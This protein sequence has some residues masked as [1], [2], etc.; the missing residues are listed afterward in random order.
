M[1]DGLRILAEF[2]VWPFGVKLL[3][4][5]HIRTKFHFIFLLGKNSIEKAFGIIHN[6]K[7]R[8]ERLL[9]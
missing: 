3:Q 4:V 8:M 5:A 1:K 7:N 2:L 6:N 9:S